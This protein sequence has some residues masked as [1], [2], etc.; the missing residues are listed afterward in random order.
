MR[1]PKQHST[2]DIYNFLEKDVQRLEKL[3]N[4]INIRLANLL[5][6]SQTPA[7]L[8]DQQKLRQ[9]REAIV[10]KQCLNEQAPLQQNFKNLWPKVMAALNHPGL[11]NENGPTKKKD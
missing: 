3:D 11:L 5:K 1:S 2:Y 7:M 6:Y 9:E 8:A 10:L 4:F